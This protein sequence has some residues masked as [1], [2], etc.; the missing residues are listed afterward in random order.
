MTYKV[1]LENAPFELEIGIKKL[2]ISGSPAGDIVVAEEDGTTNLFGALG[3]AGL[4]L[5]VWT[6]T[7]VRGALWVPP[8]LSLHSLRL[9]NAMQWHANDRDTRPPIPGR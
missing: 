5:D 1:P 3:D 2:V 6:P 8:V 9:F 4:D 7:C